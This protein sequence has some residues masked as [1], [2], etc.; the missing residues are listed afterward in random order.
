MMVM[1]CERR[2]CCDIQD[3]MIPSSGPLPCFF[4]F[5]PMAKGEEKVARVTKV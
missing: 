5:S 4:S 3:C 2:A 1:V